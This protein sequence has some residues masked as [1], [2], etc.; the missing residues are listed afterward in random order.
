MT[1]KL[2]TEQIGREIKESKEESFG[3]R[4]EVE[5][6]QVGTSA[7]IPQSSI[8]KIEYKDLNNQNISNSGEQNTKNYKTSTAIREHKSCGDM[9]G[10][11][12]NSKGPNEEL[13]L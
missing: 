7:E 8:I 11:L 1:E 3:I 10:D 12:I 6:S 2:N 5:L 9:W 4:P 13:P